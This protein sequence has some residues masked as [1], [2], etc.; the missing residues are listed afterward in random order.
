MDLILI[1][2]ATLTSFII[3]EETEEMMRLVET[4]HKEQEDILKLKEVAE[5]EFRE[6]VQL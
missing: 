4:T 3:Q 5:E 1:P 2:G 6:V